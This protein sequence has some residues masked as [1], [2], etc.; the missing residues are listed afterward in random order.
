MTYEAQPIDFAVGGQFTKKLYLSGK[1]LV[2][3]ETQ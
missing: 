2:R 1:L 3:W